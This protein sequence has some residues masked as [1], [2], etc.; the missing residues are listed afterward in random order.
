MLRSTRRQFLSTTVAAGVATSLSARSLTAASANEE[1]RL[2]F[3][4][5]GGRAGKLLSQFGSLRGVAIT[6]LC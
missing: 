4:G 3:I 1:V 2:G 6:A 5:C